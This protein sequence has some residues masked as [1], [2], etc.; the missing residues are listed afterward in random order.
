[1]VHPAMRV[2]TVAHNVPADRDGRKAGQAG[3]T[4]EQVA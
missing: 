2:A 3:A 4:F 1:M